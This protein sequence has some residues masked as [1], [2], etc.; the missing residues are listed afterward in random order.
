MHGKVINLCCYMLRQIRYEYP[1]LCQ[2]GKIIL[3]QIFLVVLLLRLNF[4]CGIHVT[5]ESHCIVYLH[6]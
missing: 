2:A 1:A 5:G 4:F 3:Q 6:V